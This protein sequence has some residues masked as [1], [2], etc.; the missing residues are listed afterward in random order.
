MGMDV[1]GTAP[2]TEAGEYFRANVWYW[3]PLW[4]YCLTVAE[5]ANKVESGHTN[6]GDG[7][8]ADDAYELGK[9]LLAEIASGRT[10][11]HQQA[12][13]AELA[14]LPLDN[15]SVCNG[16]GE[17]TP[18][19]E[20]RAQHAQLATL[21]LPVIDLP[22][23]PTTCH[24]CGGVGQVANWNTNYPFSVEVVQEFADFAIASGGFSIC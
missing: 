6:D 17:F 14:N 1:Y 11:A 20:F 13:E 2:A 4:D 5:V 21:G 23:E 24:R 15:C 19:A 7:L 9:I 16:S 8:D 18:D 3:H 10:L 12:Y 22:T